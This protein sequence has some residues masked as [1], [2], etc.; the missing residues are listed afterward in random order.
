MTKTKE[1]LV[2]FESQQEAILQ[3]M[4]DVAA[5]GGGT[6]WVHGE[7]CEFDFFNPDPHSDCP[8]EPQRIDVE[9]AS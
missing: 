1:P 7:D 5:E 6:I 3:A 2:M 8:C 9:A 4:A